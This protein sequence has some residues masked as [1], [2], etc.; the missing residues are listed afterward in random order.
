MR[1]RR[2]SKVVAQLGPGDLRLLHDLAVLRLVIDDPRGPARTRLERK[3]GPELA[4]A[5]RTAHDHTLVAK[6]A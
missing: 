1:R 6:A 5:L 3:L 4:R 2:R